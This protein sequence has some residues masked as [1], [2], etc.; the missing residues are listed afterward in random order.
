M[1]NHN[2]LITSDP[3]GAI[4]PQFYG[5]SWIYFI[6]LVT[7]AAGRIIMRDLDY[8]SL[9]LLK[10]NPITNK[11][12]ILHRIFSVFLQII[13]LATFMVVSLIIGEY[14]LGIQSKIIEQLLGI[15]ILSFT[16]LSLLCCLIA[17]GI[18]IPKS[19]LRKSAIYG[20]TVITIILSMFPY[21][22]EN[23]Y[24]FQFLSF[25]YYIDLVG[26]IAYHY[27]LQYLSPFIIVMM[28]FILSGAYIWRRSNKISYL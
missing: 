4:Y 24:F 10:G 21:F 23:L 5:Y 2:D 9:D 16:Y 7:I 20:F 26:M 13:F 28:L 15:A 27:P 6:F 22:N 19:R 12:V 14:L 11:Q 25:L 17:I 18:R 1:R 3:L 8:N